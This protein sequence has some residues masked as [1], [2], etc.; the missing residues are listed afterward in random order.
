MNILMSSYLFAPSVGGIETVSSILAEEFTRLGANVTVV[1]GTPASVPDTEPY[2]IERRPSAA[3]MLKLLKW[4]D[5]FFQNNISLNFSWPL[6]L[7]RRPLVIALHTWIT[8]ANGKKS[9]QDYLKQRFLHSAHCISVSRAVAAHISAPSTVIGNPYDDSE[10][11][12][13]PGAMRTKDLVFLGRLVSDKGVDLLIDALG[14]LKARGLRPSLT[15]IGGGPDEQLLR[16]AAAQNGVAAQI[17]F[18]GV[19]RGAELVSLL[20]QHRVMVV[21]SRWQEPFGIVALEGIACGC[22]VVAS[23]GGGLPDAMGACGVAFK[24][25]DPGD[26]ADTL[27]SLFEH[28]DRISELQSNGPAHLARHTRTAVAQCYLDVLE[29]AVID[30]GRARS[31]AGVQ[32]ARAVS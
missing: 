1:T 12:K 6:A 29:K 31:G 24:R 23:D 18:A 20:N 27:A 11:F 8:R 9:W 30:H 13:I 4:S 17:E 16:A 25:G 22:A 3:T 19:K 15:V 28:P 21:P 10:F 26:L 14:K 5:V 7:V 32:P 2:R